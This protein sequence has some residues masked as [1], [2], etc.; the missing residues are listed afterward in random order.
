ME[1]NV[2]ETREK[3]S[4]ILN[5]TENGEEVVIVRRGKKIAKLVPF[6]NNVVKRLPDLRQF[7]ASI[8]VTKKGLSDAVF[9]DR[10]E[11]RY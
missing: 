2:K 10:D 3:F 9:L 8:S 7:R 5:R 4:S 11:G 6:N 1:V